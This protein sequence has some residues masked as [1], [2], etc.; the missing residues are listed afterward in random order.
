MTSSIRERL[1]GLLRG[2]SSNHEIALGLAVGVFVS[3]FPIY[4]PQMLACLAIVVI[5][6][7]LNKIAVFLGVQFSWLYPLVVY[8]DYQVGRLIM[9]GEHPA[10]Q[11]SDF[12][13]KG[14]SHLLS[15]VKQLFPLLLAGSLVSGA[16]AAL[17]TYAIAM[18]LL[19]KYRI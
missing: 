7:R 13:E 4:G 15:L 14:F 1:S 6:R 10:F 18:G 2:N 3:F 5:F 11:M 8:C 16:V 17:L 9:P 12:R 19:R